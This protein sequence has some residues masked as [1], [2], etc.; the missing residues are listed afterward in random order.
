MIEIDNPQ[1]PDY[2]EKRSSADKL[3]E[4][5]GKGQQHF[6]SLRR[7][8]RDDYLL[9]LRE[10]G[11]KNVKGPRI[12]ASE[13]PQAGSVVLLK[14]NLPRG[15]RRMGR[16]TKL[17]PAQDGKFRAAKIFIPT[18]EDLKR[19]LNVL[20]P[21]KCSNSQEVELTQDEQ[22]KEIEQDTTPRLRPTLHERQQIKQRKSYK[23]SS[24]LK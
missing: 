17:I 19:P 21:L 13:D 2:K 20:H 23:D 24:L 3:L 12:Q 6:N 4:L 18:K 14:D 7:D 22:L 9:N 10:R 5:W 1:D 11:Q 16:N 8:W 15:V